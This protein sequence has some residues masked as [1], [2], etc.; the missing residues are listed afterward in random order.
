MSVLPG[1]VPGQMLPSYIV[2][3]QPKR[4]SV[5]ELENGLRHGEPPIIARISKDRLLIDVRTLRE[6]D[7]R[8]IAERVAELLNAPPRNETQTEERN[9]P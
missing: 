7:E 9:E 8:I 1:A 5:T 2:A 4:C 3:L 6:P